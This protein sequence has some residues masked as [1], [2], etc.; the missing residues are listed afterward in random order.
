MKL[1]LMACVFFAGVYFGLHADPEGELVLVIEQIQ[2][3]ITDVT[4]R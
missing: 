2:A 4:G 3:L 1:V